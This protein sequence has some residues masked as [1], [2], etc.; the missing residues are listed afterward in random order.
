MAKETLSRF[1]LQFHSDATENAYRQHFLPVDV[2]QNKIAILIFILPTVLFSYS[3]YLLFGTSDEFYTLS[4]IRLFEV[5]LSLLFYHFISTTKNI[6]THDSIVSAWLITLFLVIFYVNLTR[7]PEYLH[8]SFIDS[9]TLF[10]CY[11]LIYTRFILQLIPALIFSIGNIL[12]IFI[13]KSPLSALT[14]VVLLASTAMGNGLGIFISRRIHKYRRQ[15]YMALQNERILK[16]EL[17]LLANTDSLTEVPNRR[18]FFCEA[19]KELLRSKRYSH[20]CV[21]LI[22]DIDH[23]KKINDKFGHDIGDIALKK[24]A[25]LLKSHTRKIDVLG[26][27]GGEEFVLLLPETNMENAQHIVQRIIKDCQSIIVKTPTTDCTFTV[28]AGLTLV[29]PSDNTVIKIIKRADAALY[30]A[31]DLGRNQYQV[32]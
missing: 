8:H 7:P 11:V 5:V 30:K 16:Q 13:S 6:R 20:S 29:D 15:E 22:F 25:A 3:D 12:I 4:Y 10:S 18:C 24:F 1:H 23:F 2:I 32:A 27:F 19:E 17:A 21:A 28:S 26:R 9:L 31:K 14:I